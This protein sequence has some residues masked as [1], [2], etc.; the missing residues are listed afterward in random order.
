MIQE[1]SA[2]LSQ[3][4]ILKRRFDIQ[5]L[6]NEGFVQQI[7]EILS[8][9]DT[10]A[11]RSNGYNPSQTSLET[12]LMKAMQNSP[13]QMKDEDAARLQLSPYRLEFIRNQ[14][15]GV[16]RYDS[17][18]DRE[19]GVA[20]AHPDTLNWIFKD[21]SGQTHAWDN[22]SQWLESDDQIYWITGKMGS[23][24]STLMKYISQELP[25]SSAAGIER[26]C[27]P[28]LLRWAQDRPLFIA[29]FYFWAGS[30]EGTRIQT[31]VEGL[32]RTLLTQ[33]L[34]AY[35]ESAPRVSPRRWE[36]L[37]LFN[38]KSKP[39]GIPELKVM[40]SKAI[41]YVSSVAKVCLFIDGLDEFEGEND[42]LQGMI[43]WFKVMVETS[44][45]KVCLASRPWRVFEDAL[46]DRPHLLMENLNSQDIQQYVWMRFHGDSNFAA[47]KKMEA[48]FCNQLLD[49]IVTKAEGVFLWVDLVCTGLLQAM[50]RGDL[51]SDLRKILSSLPVQ[52]EKL[53]GYILE[54]L[55]SDL[56]DHAAKYFLLLQACLGRP[57]A[58]IFSL[59]DDIGEDNEFCF[60]I[61]KEPLTDA[62]LQYR[63]TELRKRLNSR[64]KGILSLSMEPLDSMERRSHPDRGTVQYC[65]RSAKDFLTMSNIRGKLV[66]MLD[67]PFDPHLRLC[68]SYLSR[69]RCCASNASES[70][71]RTSICKCAEHA[72]KVAIENNDVMI[73][74]L[75]DFDLDFEA[76]S[77]IDNGYFG[78]YPWF[79]GNLLSF[80]VVLGVSEYLKCKL[81]RV[82][83]C[84]VIS[85]SIRLTEGGWELDG[86]GRSSRSLYR[87]QAEINRI[88][89]FLKATRGKKV[90]WPLLL[91]TLLSAILP[92]PEIVSLLLENGADPNLVIRCAAWK[93]SAL[94]VVLL[95]LRGLDSYDLLRA[96]D[97]RK[98]WVDSI[99]LLLRYGAKPDRSDVQFLRNF[100]GEDVIQALKVP[101]LSYHREFIS[102]QLESIRRDRGRRGNSTGLRLRRVVRLG[103]LTVRNTLGGLKHCI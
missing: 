30:N 85:S 34:E 74:V 51:I 62:V 15:I 37:C 84:V 88:K 26:R 97:A 86:A 58:L 10:S 95:R 48:D 45:V 94:D 42:D 23:G 63:V 75:D 68:S 9:K 29:T 69:W 79:G 22:L 11:D 43:T 17:M 14:F 55:D 81:G 46:Q 83:G 91:D 78:P 36:N 32:Y 25:A 1:F 21:P 49:E 96:P 60:K 70:E 6:P 57:D 2:F 102:K 33:I 3:D 56:K 101:H 100:V 59:A 65:H 61:S 90:K 27:T 64:C 18:F 103:W 38:T 16:F 98:A 99:C 66:G 4:E 40:L 24:K 7:V 87:R 76:K 72:S 19:D 67:V 52:M 47:K 28:H 89:G 54:T 31:S 8:S 20:E 5:G 41:E 50:S 93:R 73:R 77:Y 92:N 71:L 39:P 82:K 35:P 13:Q 53:Y 80:V 12:D 44:P